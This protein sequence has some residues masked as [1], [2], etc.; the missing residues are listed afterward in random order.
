MLKQGSILRRRPGKMAPGE[1]RVPLCRTPI[2]GKNFVIVAKTDC[3][4]SPNLFT[5]LLLFFI[6]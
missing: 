5:W 1:V 6:H 2:D 4:F 3:L